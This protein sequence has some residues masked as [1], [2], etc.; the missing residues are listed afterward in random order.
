MLS[1]YR[2][3]Y[4]SLT[5]GN[6]LLARWAEAP[7]GYGTFTAPVGAAPVSKERREQ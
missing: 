5:A 3:N 2:K 4:P 7:A 1:G 6:R